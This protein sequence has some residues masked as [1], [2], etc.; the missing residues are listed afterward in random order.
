MGVMMD[1][2]LCICVKSVHVTPGNLRAFV[3][4]K[5]RG[6]KDGIMFEKRLRATEDVEQAFLDRR[7]MQYLYSDANGLVLMDSETFD[8]VTIPKEMVAEQI[9]YLKPDTNVMTLVCD[10]T[11][12]SI[13][14]PNVVELTVTETTPQPKGA[15]AT[16][17]MKDATLETGLHTRVPPFIEVGEVVR[18]STENGEYLSKAK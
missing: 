14:M 2:K 17:Q 8:Q 15:T 3:Q 6:V 11:V 9:G 4:A 18:I 10:G 13:E 12:V 5:L 16:N 7:E 1:G